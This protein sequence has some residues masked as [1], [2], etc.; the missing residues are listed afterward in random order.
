[1]NTFF[2]IS[3]ALK[4][5]HKGNKK[6]YKIDYKLCLGKKAQK[7]TGGASQLEV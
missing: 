3:L 2:N 6:M 1:M 4:V 5:D 7:K